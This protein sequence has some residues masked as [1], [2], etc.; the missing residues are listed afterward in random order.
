MKTPTAIFLGLVL[1]AVAIFFR[2]PSTSP[3]HA[4]IM[5]D[6]KYI[7]WRMNQHGSHIL[8]TK[9]GHVVYCDQDAC[10]KTFFE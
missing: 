7:G 3:A 4:G 5:G 6:G 10:R 8:N 2:Q 1:I 9:T